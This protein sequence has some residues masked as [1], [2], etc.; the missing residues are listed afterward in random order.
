[1]S[2]EH[3]MIRLFW[4]ASILFLLFR[5]ASTLTVASTVLVIAP[6]NTVANSAVS[7]LKGYGIPYR[8]YL[9]SNT[10]PALN[11]SADVGDFGAIVMLDEVLPASN[12]DEIH[13]YQSAFGVRFVRL[14]ANPGAESGTDYAIAGAGCCDT[15][16]E[17]LISITNATGFTTA[18]LKDTASVSSQ[19]LYHYPAKIT[20]P[21]I[22]WE[23]AQFGAGGP[24]TSATVAGVINRIGTRQQM[25]WFLPFSTDW[26][27]TSN[28]LQHVWIHW[29]TRGLYAG[30]RR[31]QLNTQVDDVFLYT[32]LFKPN[33]SSFRVRTADLDNLRDWIPVMNAKLPAGSSYFVELGYNGNGNIELNDE[34]EDDETHYDICLPGPIDYPEQP[35]ETA[36]TIEWKKPLGTGV[37]FW[38]LRP[39]T[40]GYTEA[41]VAYDALEVWF[42][43]TANL[44]AFAHVS[45]TFTH[46]DLTNATYNDTA[47]EIAF[48]RAWFAQTGIDKAARW[49][50]K[51]LIP[52]AITGLRNGDA[53]KAWL[54]NGITGV[55][56]DNTRPGLLN[57][58]NEFWPL[59][60]NVNDN[61]YAGLTIMP[62]WATE[63]FYNCDTQDCDLALWQFVSK[64]DGTWDQLIEQTRS[65]NVRNLLALR[66]DA[67]MFHQANLRQTDVANSVVNGVSA[68][69]SLLQIWVEVVLGEMTK[70]VTWPIIST[71]HDDL[72]QSF[73][74]RMARDQCNYG[75][76]YNYDAAGTSIVSVTVSALVST[77]TARIPVTFPGP[78]QSQG[79]ATPEQLGSD[80]LTLWVLLEGTEQTFQLAT[81]VK[82]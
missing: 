23:F 38:P 34:F 53:I 61:G 2:R 77:C 28:F 8:I 10:F 52:P 63:I 72:V 13:A 22:A 26:S 14:N 75:M 16:V 81:P 48:N 17:Q 36:G 56:G 59:I 70:L 41:C 66:H 6:D 51:G 46:L 5:T 82:L 58:Q 50:G 74:D 24:Y 64:P 31:L 67:F 44:N 76:T 39:A 9:T 30:F 18:G 19:N 42:S 65:T 25:L 20:D 79:S 62:R 4:A 68:K 60:S 35:D 1:M 78:V 49:S 45:H 55:V 69:R 7:G 21:S 54:D 15:N 29:A 12:V 11:R 37:D 33:T 40:Y 57:S 47:K 80:P 73:L 71:K 27:P 32:E 43:N 3:C